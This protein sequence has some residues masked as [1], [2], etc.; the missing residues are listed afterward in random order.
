MSLIL[1]VLCGGAQCGG[2]LG[3]LMRSFITPGFVVCGSNMQ[4][5]G[6]FVTVVGALYKYRL[7]EFVDVIN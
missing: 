1:T 3:W 7:R 2:G 5:F 6:S 4:G